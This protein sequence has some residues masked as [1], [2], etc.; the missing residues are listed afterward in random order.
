[1]YFAQNRSIYPQEQ[2]RIMFMLNLM[3]AGTPYIWSQHYFNTHL[4]NRRFKPGSKDKFFLLLDK[5]FVDQNERRTALDKLEKYKMKDGQPAMDFFQQMEIYTH[6]AGY[7]TNDQYLICHIEKFIPRLLVEHLHNCTTR[8]PTK[9]R[10]YRDKIIDIDNI[11]HRLQA[12]KN[13][14]PASVSPSSAPSSSSRKNRK[15]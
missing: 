9:Y 6:T 11:Q 10:H 5:S 12:I 3:N 15:H 2:D 14:T 8:I 13:P 1:M 7:M 4:K